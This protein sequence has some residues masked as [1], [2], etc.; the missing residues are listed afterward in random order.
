MSEVE[1]R[2]MLITAGYGSMGVNGLKA[3]ISDCNLLEL[4]FFL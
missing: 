3:L 1:Q 4:V 2:P